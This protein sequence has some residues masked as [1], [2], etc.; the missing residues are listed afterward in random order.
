MRWSEKALCQLAGLA[1]QPAGSDIF[2]IRLAV[3]RS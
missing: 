3:S 1:M 2:E